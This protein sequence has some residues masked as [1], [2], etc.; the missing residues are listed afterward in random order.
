MKLNS[1]MPPRRGLDSVRNMMGYKHGALALSDN[2]RT[3]FPHGCA[4]NASRRS[5]FKTPG[6][7]FRTRPMA[8]ATRSAAS[9]MQCAALG[10]RLTG[11]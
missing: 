9:F 1:N 3:G 7:A 4:R 10:T 6:T 2:H 8:S 11:F 5:A